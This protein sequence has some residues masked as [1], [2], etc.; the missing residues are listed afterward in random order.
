MSEHTFQPREEHEPKPSEKLGADVSS[1]FRAE[2]HVPREVDRAVIEM[3]R[4][5][6]AGR[7]RSI[8]V[9]RWASVSAAAAAVL[10]AVSVMLQQERALT[11][12]APTTPP[13]AAVRED[14]DGNGRVDILDAFALAR[15][16]EASGERRQHWDV[17]G[18][19]D[20]NQVDVDTVAMAAVSLD[21]GTLQ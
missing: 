14:V 21:R 4:R 19:G 15:H 3:A 17:N 12:H 6:F 10:L 8:L 1:L 2:V 18:D 11:P 9:L 13:E 20:V 16:I 7:R 5:R